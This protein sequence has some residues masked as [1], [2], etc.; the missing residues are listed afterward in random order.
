MSGINKDD[1]VNYYVSLISGIDANILA[2][3]YQR[4]DLYNRIEEIR[5]PK[6]VVVRGFRLRKKLSNR[7][8]LHKSRKNGR[9]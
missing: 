1:A 4:E 3:Q 5:N 6:P 2:L 9:T 7:Q 8:K